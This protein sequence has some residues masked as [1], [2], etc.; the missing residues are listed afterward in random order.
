MGA[1]DEEIIHMDGLL[2][3][4][5]GLDDLIGLQEALHEDGL[6]CAFSKDAESGQIASRSPAASSGVSA[7]I[8][9]P[10]TSSCNDLAAMHRSSISPRSS[11]GDNED[12]EY[13]GTNCRPSST[14]R[15][16]NKKRGRANASH[17]EHPSAPMVPKVEPM[18]FDE[19]DDDLMLGC[20]GGNVSHSTVEKRRRDRINTLIDLLAEQVP[21][22]SAKYRHSNSVGGEHCL[23]AC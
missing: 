2:E 4:F 16:Q 15:S 18:C 10:G 19:D 1:F 14:P 13:H 6:P 8:S 20:K 22:L 23:L 7:Q 21:P 5:A 11:E 12:D 17:Q 3:S 9:L